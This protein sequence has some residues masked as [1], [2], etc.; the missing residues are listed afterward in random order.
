MPP[1][2]TARLTYKD[3]RDYELLP[4]RIDELEQAISRGE[5]ILADPNLYARDPQR[6]AGV[7]QGL[8]NARTEKHAAEERWLKLAELVEG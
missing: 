6:F 7:M 5:A 3:Q 1:P 4:A 8:A 2:R